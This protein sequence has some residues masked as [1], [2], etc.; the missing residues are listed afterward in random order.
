MA[1]ELLHGAGL[2]ADTAADGR[3]ALAKV[4]AHDYDLILM[5]MQMPEMD[6][7]EATRAIR[8]LPGWGSKPILAMSANAFSEDRQACTEA[9][10]DD[11]IAK[12]VEPDQLYATLAQWLPLTS[13]G[14]DAQTP[15]AAPVAGDVDLRGLSAVAGLDL[16]HGLSIV[17]NRETYLGLLALFVDSHGDDPQRLQQMLDAGDLPGVQRLAHTLK[18]SAG[19]LGAMR[20]SEAANKLQSSVRRGAART[21][22]DGCVQRLIDELLQLVAGIRDVLSTD[23]QA[24]AV[25][26]PARVDEVLA[27]LKPLLEKGNIAATELAQAEE[28][29]LRAAMGTDG[30][31]FLRRIEHF[32]YEG[33]LAIVR[34][35]TGADGDN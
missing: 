19:N 4:Q 10:M 32:D 34:G 23:S 2:A 15:V 27:K 9:G 26:D 11:F 16:A 6:G 18:G 7:L 28:Q 5:D 14:E 29:L 22:I 24:L 8:A 30:G 31:E 25:I 33:A 20:V 12:P 35:R 17:L 1:L 21:E 13:L 3:E